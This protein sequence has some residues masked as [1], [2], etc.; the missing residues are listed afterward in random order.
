[1]ENNNKTA[2][3]TGATSGFGWE[4]AKLFAKDGHNV[5]M[6]ARDL[7]KLIKYS[8]ELTSKFPLVSVNYFSLDLA[9]PDAANKLYQQAKD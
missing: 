2:L 4:F 5:I 3:I 1:M 6:V 8:G 9:Q 7:D